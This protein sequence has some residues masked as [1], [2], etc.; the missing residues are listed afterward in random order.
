MASPFINHGIFP[1]YNRGGS[2]VWHLFQPM[3]FFDL[4][5]I[6][7]RNGKISSAGA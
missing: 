7:I 4:F 2:A 6:I 1:G 5:Q 3:V